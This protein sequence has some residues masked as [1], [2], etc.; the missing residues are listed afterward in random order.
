MAGISTSLENSFLDCLGNASGFNV[1]AV[2]IQLHTAD[3][4]SAGTTAVA[5]NNTRK[6]VTFAAAS[7]GSKASSADI[8]WTNVST[9]ETY[10]HV[11]LWTASSNGTYLWSGALS[12]SKTVAV[13][14]TFTISSGSLTVGLS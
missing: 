8:T 5:G 14:D 7:S 3:P 6:A 12:A 1:A 2:Y 9:A 10:T 11:S 4:G 13:G